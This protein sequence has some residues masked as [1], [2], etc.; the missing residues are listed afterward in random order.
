MSNAFERS[1]DIPK[2]VS[3]DKVIKNVLWLFL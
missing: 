3:L 2:G 1:K